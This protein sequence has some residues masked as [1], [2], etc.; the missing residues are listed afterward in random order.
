MLWHEVGLICQQRICALMRVGNI[1][2]GHLTVLFMHFIHHTH[3]CTVTYLYIT[4]LFQ[5]PVHPVPDPLVH[6]VLN[7]AFKHFKHKEG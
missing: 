2:A 1:S 4:L 7:L 6:E 5:I 3:T